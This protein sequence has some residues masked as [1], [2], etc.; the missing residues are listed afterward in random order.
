MR[1]S[2]ERK[3]RRERSVVQRA[4]REEFMWMWEKYT[5][6]LHWLFLLQR[7]S[8]GP[9]NHCLIITSME[10]RNAHEKGKKTGEENK[11]TGEREEL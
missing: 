9:H 10:G 3:R 8:R 6:L 11:T 4:R 5:T 7:G 1:G 2:G